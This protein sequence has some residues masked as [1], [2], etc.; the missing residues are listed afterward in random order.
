MATKII[1]SKKSFAS[2]SNA[3]A[4]SGL[5]KR[6]NM[7]QEKETPKKPLKTKA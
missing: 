6:G 2:L 5:H 1:R 7:S 4:F 3:R